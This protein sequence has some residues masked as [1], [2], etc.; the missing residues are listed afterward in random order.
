[1]SWPKVE[2]PSQ[3]MEIDEKLLNKVLNLLKIVTKGGEIRIPMDVD[4]PDKEVEGPHEVHEVLALF[5]VLMVE[6]V[7]SNFF[8]MVNVLPVCV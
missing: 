7:M 6:D 4:K 3:A 8:T 1:M 2:N 5:L